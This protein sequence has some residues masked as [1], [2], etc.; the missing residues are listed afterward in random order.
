MAVEIKWVGPPRSYT[1]GRP[2][3]IQFVVLHYTAG[4]EGPMSAENGAAY[5]KRRIDGTSTHYFTDSAGPALQEVHD[6]DQ[7]HAAL[8]HG[9]AIGVQIE[10]CGT[11]QTRAQ[12]LDA[13]S[14]ATL[15]TTAALVAHLCKAHDLPAVRLSVAQCRDAWYATAAKRPR[16]IVDHGT[17]TRAFPE[18]GGTHTDLGPDFPWDVF[19]T[20]VEE[21]MAGMDPLTKDQTTAAVWTNDKIPRPAD[22]FGSGAGATVA[23]V[24][25]VGRVFDE[26]AT[27]REDGTA[28]PERS[29]AATVLTLDDKV[30]A[31]A[32]AVAELPE[33]PIVVDAAVLRAGLLDPVVLEAIAKAVAGE[34]AGR[35]DG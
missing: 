28:P 5:D 14:R 33:H 23:A 16:G 4:S 25:L 9:N 10:I 1:A 7:A 6:V 34:L 17:V 8:Y 3:R 22:M 20:M 27:R 24:S 32:A 18:D 21:E 15:E 11:A 12:W 29:L 35:L 26:V 31:L 19:M 2:R 13:V 30:D